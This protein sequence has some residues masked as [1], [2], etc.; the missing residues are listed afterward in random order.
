MVNVCPLN[1]V[2][3]DINSTLLPAFTIFV[4]LWCMFETFNFKTLLSTKVA[5][6]DCPEPDSSVFGIIILFSFM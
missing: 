4:P 2:L 5:V 6:I 1:V 3:L